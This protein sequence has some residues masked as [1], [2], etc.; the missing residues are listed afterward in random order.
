MIDLDS[1][2]GTGVNG[3]QTEFAELAE[4]DVLSIGRTEL[5]FV[6]FGLAAEEV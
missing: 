6:P 1:A 2:H 3:Q 5:T 4:G